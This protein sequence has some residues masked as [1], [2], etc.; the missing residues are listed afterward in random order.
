MTKKS[1]FANP[2]Y[3]FRLKKERS[4]LT[5]KDKFFNIENLSYYDKIDT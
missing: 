3:Q 2:V 1:L 5:D 4:Y